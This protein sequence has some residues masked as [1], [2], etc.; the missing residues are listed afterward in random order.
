MRIIYQKGM[1]NI[2]NLN[3]HDSIVYSLF[4]DMYKTGSGVGLQCNHEENSVQ[5][6]KINRKCEAIYKAVKELDELI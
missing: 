1:F 2:D 5:Y 6:L 4:E 3:N